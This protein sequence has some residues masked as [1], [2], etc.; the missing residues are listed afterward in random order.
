MSEERVDIH[1]LL[2]AGSFPTTR[3]RSRSDV[4][5]KDPV[6]PLKR[7]PRFYCGTD[8][9]ID[10]A[11]A[12]D[13]QPRT[14]PRY[15]TPPPPPT[16]EDCEDDDGEFADELPKCR[17]EPNQ[18]YV[19]TDNDEF[20]NHA[21]Q[22]FVLVSKPG[23][24]DAPRGSRHA[25]EPTVRGGPTGNPPEEKPDTNPTK[26]AA[27]TVTDAGAIG[28]GAA[29]AAVAAAAA[30]AAGKD[31]RPSMRRMKSPADLP[32][33]ETDMYGPRGEGSKQNRSRSS[34]PSYNTDRQYANTTRSPERPTRS[35]RDDLLSP[36]VTKSRP[37]NREQTYYYDNSNNQGQRTARQNDRPSSTS[38]RRQ[39]HDGPSYNAGYSVSPGSGSR[40]R[41][42][43][44]QYTVR[45]SSRGSPRRR[46]EGGIASDGY[47][48]DPPDIRPDPSKRI[49]SPPRRQDT[50]PRRHADQYSDDE[51]EVSSTRPSRRNPI[52]IQ[53][54]A[55]NPND[56]RHPDSRLRARS[57]T[58][59]S[60]NPNGHRDNA[61]RGP[62][63]PTST[64]PMFDSPSVVPPY[65]MEDVMP[66]HDRPGYLEPDYWGSSS[67][68][69]SRG[70]QN[71]MPIPIRIPA[72]S[73]PRASIGG[74]SRSPG[75]SRS[76][77]QSPPKHREV[78]QDNPPVDVASYSPTDKQHQSDLS[79]RRYLEDPRRLGLPP[80]PRCPR[81][82]PVAGMT[83]WLTLPECENFTICPTC[84]DKVFANSN[85]GSHFTLVPRQV[86]NAKAFCDFGG[87]LWYV[88][89][90]LITL[91]SG[92]RDLR[93]FKVVSKIASDHAIANEHCPGNRVSLRAWHSLR[94][95]A[96]GRPVP[97]FNVCSECTTII[98]ALFPNVKGALTEPGLRPSCVCSMHSEIDQTKF[99]LYVNALERA[100]D[101]AAAEGLTVDMARLAEDVALVS[102]A[103]TCPRDRPV[104]NEKWYI[105]PWL[106]EL[107]VCTACFDEA[108]YPLLARDLRAGRSFA[109]HTQRM[110]VGTCQ[111]YSD[112]MREVYAMA[113]ERD[114]ARLLQ[115]EVMDRRDKEDEIKRRM[116][117]LKG[118]RDVS[119]E[120]EIERLEQVWK[121][122]E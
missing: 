49:A 62:R 13:A 86:H 97:N 23:E 108:V 1:D 113:L 50:R 33:I 82:V 80:L 94:D 75:T 105:L 100:S 3:S 106:P 79:I 73:G 32:R 25:G 109:M 116:A 8:G 118:S 2:Q 24:V 87:L 30:A 53:T 93:L 45:G 40:S 10:T 37:R 74:G 27:P 112:R 64:A 4:D 9:K 104:S 101:E 114:D 67:A 66:S 39:Q 18:E 88:V 20:I 117:V 17:G 29:A 59:T 47:L 48:D 41:Y 35:S 119:A 31:T 55:F 110:P 120:G 121:G 54:T 85:F 22:R 43:P 42:D 65:P 38:S 60:T 63:S 84:Y 81:R 103:S 122:L 34:A 72:P 51:P 71:T 58:G 56:I 19:L 28:T 11:L 52:V 16:V 44:Q 92:L 78:W 90:W 99:F 26:V 115:D 77:Q 83:D 5:R 21:E 107:T 70:P 69:G 91:K 57:T 36:Q 68:S 15:Q 7:E 12:S 96:T 89:A 61:P 76:W 111:L 14:T 98:G 95:P 102:C 6:E 46:G